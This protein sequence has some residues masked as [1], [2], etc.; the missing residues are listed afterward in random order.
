MGSGSTA[1]AAL[2]TGRDYVGYDTDAG[3]RRG[4][5]RPA[6]TPSGSRSTPWATTPRR[7][8]GASRPGSWPSTPSSTPGSPTSSS[9]S[10]S[11]AGTDFALRAVDAQGRRWYVDVA[12]GFTTGPSGLRRTDLLW[13]AVGMAHT[14]RAHDP[15]CRTL[16]LTPDAAQRHRARPPS[17]TWPSGQRRH[18][19]PR[20]GRP[21]PPR[22]AQGAARHVTTWDPAA[23][24]AVLGPAAAT[25]PGPDRP[26]GPGRAA[27][28]GSWT[29]VAGP[30]R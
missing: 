18:P 26:P 20:A 9:G 6:S 17:A 15:D 7:R 4:G 16:V 1:V 29:W 10:R 11:P 2:R 27:R 8:P 24:R 22:P 19:R 3:L 21:R 5:R 14:I 23:V 13:R 25:G 28:S 12:G 30:G